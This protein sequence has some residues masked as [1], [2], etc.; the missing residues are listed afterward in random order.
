MAILTAFLVACVL[1][2]STAKGSLIYIFLIYILLL[3]CKIIFQ[4]N[5]NVMLCYV[6]LCY[7]MLCYVMLCY[8]MLC[9]FMLCYV[10]L[11]YVML[12]YTTFSLQIKTTPSY[13]G[14]R[15]WTVMLCYVVYEFY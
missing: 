8:V 9:Y 5:S 6:I 7:V 15:V 11:C 10:M 1:A 12:C 3:C 14:A 4:F 13:H 2:L